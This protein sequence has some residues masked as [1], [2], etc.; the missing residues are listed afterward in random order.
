MTTVL[1]NP[2]NSSAPSRSPFLPE[3]GTAKHRAQPLLYS[4]GYR[5]TA[6]TPLELAVAISNTPEL[7]ILT[8]GIF[9]DAVNEG[10]AVPIDTNDGNL[11][12]EKFLD[13]TYYLSGAGLVA[14]AMDRAI[15]FV[16]RLL[17]RGQFADCDELLRRVDLTRMPSSLRRAFLMITFPAK[18][19]LPNRAFAFHQTLALLSVEKGA[20]VA[21]RM[22][23][24]L[25]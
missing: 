20:D 4:G 1:N 11:K 10:A 12:L 2:Q 8:S 21:R 18:G 14:L 5:T 19:K 7:S 22:L 16:D 15:D 24:S 13:E 9:V 25:T 6:E 3:G 17:G 23:K